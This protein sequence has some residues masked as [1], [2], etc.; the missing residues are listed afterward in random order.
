M[1]DV[2]HVFK[3]I[4]SVI[5]CLLC[6]A[7][8]VLFAYTVSKTQAPLEPEKYQISDS[9]I[10]N[11]FYRFLTNGVDSDPFIFIFGLAALFVKSFFQSR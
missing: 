4:G 1:R 9:A 11:G 2:K 10:I 5:C 8:I 7:V 3:T 6:I